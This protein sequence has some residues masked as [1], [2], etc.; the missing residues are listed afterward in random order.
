MGIHIFEQSRFSCEIG[1]AIHVGPNASRALAHLGYD[2]KLLQA[3]ECRGV[4][5]CQFA[6]DCDCWGLMSTLSVGHDP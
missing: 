4:S 5:G 3:V 1:A 6:F 2:P